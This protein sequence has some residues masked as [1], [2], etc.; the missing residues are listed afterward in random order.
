MEVLTGIDQ[1]MR[2]TADR[3]RHA[4]LFE[5]IGVILLVPLGNLVLDVGVQDMGVIGIGSAFIATVWNYVYNILFDRGML[6][7]TGSTRKTVRVRVLHAILFEAGLLVILLPLMAL[8]LGIGL[9]EAL[10]LDSAIVVFYLVYAFVYNLVYD[11]VF[12]VPTTPTASA[13][14]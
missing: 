12:P 10:I 2:S 8:Y 5:I 11:R 4:V 7:V 1:A 3:I 9:L 6:R 14:C 13:E